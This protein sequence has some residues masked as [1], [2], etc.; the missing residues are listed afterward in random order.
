M[1]KSGAERVSKHKANQSED[2]RTARLQ[3]EAA[4][5]ARKREAA[6]AAKQQRAADKD[7]AEESCRN[8]A[9]TLGPRPVAQ[10]WKKKGQSGSAAAQRKRA[11]RQR[12]AA[13]AAAEEAT[14]LVP[15]RVVVEDPTGVGDTID[16]TDRPS[17]AADFRDVVERD[18]AGTLPPDTAANIVLDATVYEGCGSIEMLREN[19]HSPQLSAPPTQ[20]STP[21]PRPR[22]PHTTP[23]DVT[24][25]PSRW[26]RMCELN[27]VPRPEPRRRLIFSGNT[28]DIHARDAYLAPRADAF[29]GALCSISR[30]SLPR[31]PSR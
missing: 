18:Q 17:W 31:M 2:A 22:K 7:I 9:E 8:A 21:P 27:A 4:R 28:T 23:P 10:C 6:R 1:V 11:Q 15:E 13:A 29:D 12:A 5:Q 14:R 26:A 25:Q 20:L 30:A 16:I 3:A 19:P 24:P